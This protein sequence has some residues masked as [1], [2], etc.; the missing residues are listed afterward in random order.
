MK[1]VLQRNGIKGRPIKIRVNFCKYVS[2]RITG[3]IRFDTVSMTVPNGGETV[4]NFYVVKTGIGV[5]LRQASP[6]T[7]GLNSLQCSH[8]M[9]AAGCFR[10]G[11]TQNS[12]RGRHF[13]TNLGHSK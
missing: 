11:V 9:A 13:R 7:P 12:V 10:K 6:V 8:E 1:T 5:S 2:D 3:R 4:M